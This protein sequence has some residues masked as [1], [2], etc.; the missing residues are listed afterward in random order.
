[1]ELHEPELIVN[2]GPVVTVRVGG[3][4]DLQSA[5]TVAQA[6]ERALASGKPEV[7]IDLGATGFMDSS[8]LNLLMTVRN[9]TRALGRSLRVVSERPQVRRLFEITGLV[10]EFGLAGLEGESHS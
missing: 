2:D 3:D 4:I 8:G 6:L 7:V 5:P 9:R 10:R 1:M